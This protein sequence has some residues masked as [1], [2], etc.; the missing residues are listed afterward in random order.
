LAATTEVPNE[1]TRQLSVRLPDET[2]HLSVLAK[3]TYQIDSRGNCRLAPT[4]APLQDEIAV[5]EADDE[6]IV[7]DTDLVPWKPLTDIVVLGHGHSRDP[8]AEL[9]LGL[10]VGLHAK[11]VVAIGD[12]RAFLGAS[13]RVRFSPPAPFT[14]VRLSFALAYGGRDHVAEDKYGIPAAKFSQYLPRTA[15]IEK[16][17]PY[18]YPRNP[19]GRGYLV[20]LSASG[21]E[22]LQ[23]PQLEDPEDRLSPERL[24]AGSAGRWTTMPVPQSFGWFGHTWFPRVGFFGV[25]PDHEKPTTILEEVRRGWAPENILKDGRIQDRFSTRAGNGA[26]LGLQVPYLRGDEDGS[27]HNLSALGPV[28]KF[29]LP[30]ERPQIWTDG[31]KGTLKKTDPVIQTLVIEPDEMRL[32]IVWRGSALAIRRYLPD[33][34]TRMPLR[35]TW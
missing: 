22:T 23:L 27:L 4:Q 29:Q 26:S 30:K 5:D 13:D 18:L 9:A 35:V 33:E 10:R 19:C 24:A 11:K 8:V 34:L 14:K 16:L 25:S 6:L 15:R 28:V 7:A 32:S 3:R 21:V 12:R 20:E 17:S 31:R 2:W 1:T